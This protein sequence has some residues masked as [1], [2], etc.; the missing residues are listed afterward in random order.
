MSH[1][2]TVRLKPRREKNNSKKETATH[3]RWIGSM[4]L[5]SGW[6]SAPSIRPMTS[7]P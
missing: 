1:D 6:P 2:F 7:P 3:N 5:L 4:P